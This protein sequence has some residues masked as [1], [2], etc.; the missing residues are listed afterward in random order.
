MQ[1]WELIYITFWK[2]CGVIY[3]KIGG[4]NDGV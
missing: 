1:I 3:L 2:A 4:N